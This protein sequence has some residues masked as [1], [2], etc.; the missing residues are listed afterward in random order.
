M[1]AYGPEVGVEA[2]ADALAW[3]WE[4]RDRLADVDNAAGY[5]FRVG[6][7]AARRY[8]RP[9]GF[10]PAPDHGRIPQIEPG[11]APALERLSQSQRVAVVAVHCFGWS[12]QEAADLLGVSHSTIRTHLAR[13]LD[14]L[15]KSLEVSLDH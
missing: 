15:R 12:Q 8:R 11:L 5:L 9:G 1:A 14:N 6:Q 3:A 4:H 2:C 10:L 7:S 13:G